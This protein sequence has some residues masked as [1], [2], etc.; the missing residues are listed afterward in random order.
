MTC[1]P[2][3][4]LN[5]FQFGVLILLPRLRSSSRTLVHRWYWYC[6]LL[7]NSNL[8]LVCN[9]LIVRDLVRLEIEIIWW[10]YKVWVIYRLGSIVDLW[11]QVRLL[12]DWRLGYVPE[13]CL[14]LL[15]VLDKHRRLWWCSKLYLLQG[16]R[17][18][19]L[20][21]G[22]WL[23]YQK[24]RLL[25]V[26][27]YF[28]TQ[29]MTDVRQIRW[30]EVSVLSLIKLGFFNFRP[31]IFL[32]RC[33]SHPCLWLYEIPFRY[34]Q[35]AELIEIYVWNYTM[36]W[37]KGFRRVLVAIRVK[38]FDS[39][40]DYRWMIR[41]DRTYSRAYSIVCSWIYHEAA[42]PT[43]ANAIL[44]RVSLRLKF[45]QLL[46][47]RGDTFRLRNSKVVSFG[48]FLSHLNLEKA[49]SITEQ[50]ILTFNNS[51]H[52]RVYKARS[53]TLTDSLTS[54]NSQVNR[55]TLTL[56]KYCWLHEIRIDTFLVF[57]RPFP[58][59]FTCSLN[60]TPELLIQNAAVYRI[61]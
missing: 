20:E 52:T 58:L 32:S 27:L 49:V 9:Y 30:V 47:K 2:I 57:R 39:A 60:I 21:S 5:E 35:I 4:W 36:I 53:F 12:L 23:A 24:L 15:L 26:L 33:A 3:F 59:E 55:S 7:P 14:L 29:I 42:C 18:Q 48:R 16:S 41:H 45:L 31:F 43:S 22:T 37:I 28:N 61:V 1:F 10:I 8:F 34:G 56:S 38:F 50:K 6:R 19:R 46:P 44:L 17:W 51:W 13:K 40:G 25:Q 54:T 11:R